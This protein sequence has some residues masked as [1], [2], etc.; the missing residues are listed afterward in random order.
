MAPL[1]DLNGFGGDAAPLSLR[2]AG[3]QWFAQALDPRLASLAFALAC[4]AAIFAVLVFCHRRRW[5]L[6][7]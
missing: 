7:L 1:I 3:Q 6:K 4:M 5:I 2:N